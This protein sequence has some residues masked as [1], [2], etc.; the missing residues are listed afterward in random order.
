MAAPDKTAQEAEAKQRAEA[1][2]DPALNAGA[3]D[4]IDDVAGADDAAPRA[5]ADAP[6]PEPRPAPTVRNANDDKRNAI[7]DRFKAGRTTANAENTDDISD[8]TRSGMPPEFAEPVEE[9]IEEEA[10]PAA[11]APAPAAPTKHKLKVRGVETELT[12][13]EVIAQAQIALAGDDYLGEAK[14]KLKEVEDLIR[15]TK[16]QRGAAPEQ[17]Q[18]RQT[19]AQNDEQVTTEAADPQHPGEDRIAKLLET[20]QFGDPEEARTLLRD[21]IAEEATKA[22]SG[23]VDARLQQDR[24]KDEGARTQKALTDFLA[25][26][27]EIANDRKARAVIEQ[28]MFEQQ[29]EDIKALGIDPATIPT[30]HGGPPNAGDIAEAHRWYRSEGF[31]VKSPKDMLVTAVADYKAWKGGGPAPTPTP[32]PAAA[33]PTRAAPA[34]AITVD[35]AA[36]RATAPQAP[37]RSAVQQRAPAPP[38]APARD[39]AAIVRSMVEKRNA[40]RGRVLV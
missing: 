7:I 40:P 8:F 25:D 31:T 27:A 18:P 20:I 23:V 3:I 17:H 9:L 12:L 11:A 22:A 26:N 38:P 14:G 13:E 1:G 21:T 10:A 34:V 4:V 24:L 6:A 30:G 36:R 2:I 35:R 15:E 29:V 39:R 16:A 28:N 33:D 5:R 19:P 32:T 37:S